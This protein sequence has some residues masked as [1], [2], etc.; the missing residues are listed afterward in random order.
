MTAN[1]LFEYKIITVIQSRSQPAAREAAYKI[2][3]AELDTNNHD[4]DSDGYIW[5]NKTIE[6]KNGN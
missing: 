5:L 3:K 4:P 2:F 6:D 1:K